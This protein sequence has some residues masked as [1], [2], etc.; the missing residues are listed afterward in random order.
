MNEFELESFEMIIELYDH[1]SVQLNELIGQYSIG[2]STLH[3]SLNHEMYRTWIG[4]FHPDEPNK[5]QGYLQISAFIVGPGD[6]SPAHASG[7]DFADG[8][9]D[10]EDDDDEETI[11]KKINL[12]KRA[13]GAVIVNNPQFATKNYQLTIAISK[14][15]NIAKDPTDSI[16]PFISARVNG[17]VLTTSHFSSASPNF[18]Q[19]LCFPVQS[20][21]LN[22]KITMRLWSNSGAALTPN[23]FIANMPE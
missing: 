11:I 17:M 10:I 18:N 3:R 14:A 1:N 4:M 12:M 23:Y 9:L 6:T 7:G 19:K 21:I 5:V 16:R 2:L 20:P 15:E 22:D 13:Q 8:Q